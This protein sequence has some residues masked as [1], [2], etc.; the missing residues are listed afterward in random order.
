MEAAIDSLEPSYFLD[1]IAYQMQNAQ[2][3]SLFDIRQNQGTHDL[4][5]DGLTIN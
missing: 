2:V 4:L 3:F 1:N 5:A